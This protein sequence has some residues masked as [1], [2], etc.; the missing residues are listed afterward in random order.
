MAWIE[1]STNKKALY[2]NVVDPKSTSPY[3]V[4]EDWWMNVEKIEQLGFSCTPIFEWL[5][6]LIQK[7]QETLKKGFN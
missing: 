6:S 5:P 1:T 7:T 4:T 2:S 3:N